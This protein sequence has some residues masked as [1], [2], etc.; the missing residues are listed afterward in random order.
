MAAVDHLHLRTMRRSLG[1][2]VKTAF[3]K[4]GLQALLR[5]AFP[6]QRP[7]IIRYHS[8]SEGNGL[9]SD[10]IAVP[11]AI[12]EKQVRYFAEHFNVISLSALIDCVQN[13]RPFP[14]NT[15]VL[16]FDD[17][18]ADNYPA[19]QILRKYGLTGVFYITAGCIESSERFWVAEVRHLLQRTHNDKVRLQV[20]D[21][22]FEASL[23]D[24]TRLKAIGQ[25]TR[26]I[27]T[28]DIRTREAIREELR[29]QTDDVPPLPD[30]LMLTWPHLR[31]MAAMGMEIGGH[32]MTHCNLPSATEEEAWMEISQCK[33][34]LEQRLGIKLSHFAYPNGGS[35]RYYTER[36]K[37]LVRQAGYLSAVTS[38]LGVVDS[39]IDPF[40]LRRV[41]TTEQLSEVLWELEEC[42]FRS[43]SAQPA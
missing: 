39:A 30:N 24:S 15:V 25:L 9:I 29:K 7:A 35:S 43:I 20:R 22:L 23:Y 17:G 14:E 12:F 38:K 31:E 19:A 1:R 33:A 28:V 5:R 2:K 18:Y 37:E 21:R 13:R 8:V 4:T 34:L 32:T 40:E 26:L 3:L 10:G 41:R 6:S 42:R 11:P 27:K 36:I 16:T